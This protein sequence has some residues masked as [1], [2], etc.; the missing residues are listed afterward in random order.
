MRLPCACRENIQQSLPCRISVTASSCLPPNLGACTTYMASC[1]VHVCIL[2]YA[3]L[4][5]YTDLNE[6]TTA[7]DLF[8]SSL[9]QSSSAHP[10]TSLEQVAPCMAMRRCSWPKTAVDYN[11]RSP[12][13]DPTMSHR[14][15]AESGALIGGATKCPPADQNAPDH[16]YTPGVQDITQDA[17][18]SEKQSA[19]SGVDCGNE[20]YIG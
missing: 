2:K 12:V 10:T 19:G 8:D 3:L 6:Q 17:I 20:G 9:S 15:P 18:G 11:S 4:Q 5:H 1:T 14:T 13:S 16:T 7:H